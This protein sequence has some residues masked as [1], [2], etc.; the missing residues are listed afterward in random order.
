MVSTGETKL[1]SKCL[2]LFVSTLGFIGDKL[3]NYKAMTMFCVGLGGAAPFG[4]L[5]L[6]KDH[7]NYVSFQQSNASHNLSSEDNH[8]N[9]YEHVDVVAEQS[10]TFP[11]L[12]IFRLL[13]FFSATTSTSLL[14][15]CGLTIC[16]KYDCD[17]GRQKLWGNNAHDSFDVS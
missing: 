11:L 3:G 10:Y 1:Y 7:Q 17:F 14:D 6:F 5:W 2:S 4:I 13:C 16:K 12:V 9:Y 8:A 15:A